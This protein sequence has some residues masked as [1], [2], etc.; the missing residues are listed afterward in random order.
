MAAHKN[1]KSIAFVSHLVLLLLQDPPMS[2]A[3][4]AER[5]FILFGKG[6]LKRGW[7]VCYIT[8]EISGNV[9]IKTVM[10]VEAASFSFMHGGKWRI[11]LNCMS[12]LYAMWRTNSYYYVIKTP[13]YF[14]VPM[15]LFTKLF[16]RRLVFWAQSDSDAYPELRPSNKFVGL[17]QDIGTR[18][19]DIIIAQNKSQLIGFKNNFGKEAILI[20]NITGQLSE[21]EERGGQSG[22]RVDIL[23]VGNSMPN[24]RYEVVVALAEMLPEFTFALAMN[25]SHPE[26]YLQAAEKCSL[27]NNIIFLGEVNPIEMESWF[28][29]SRLLLN[30]SAREGFP[31]TYLQAWQQGLPIVSICIDPDGLVGSRNLGIVFDKDLAGRLTDDVEHYANILCP[32]I[33][34]L[35]A[36]NFLYEKIS[37]NAKKYVMESHGESVL[38]EKLEKV[39]CE[40]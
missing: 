18:C 16:R 3:G 30:T 12:I 35:L 38:V 36:D 17:F 19:A 9:A 14:L 27:I 32:I 6:L 24:K 2:G 13:S 5:Q 4:G 8:D 10:P 34:K 20:P 23:W 31:N 26:R 29:R 1:N 22:E 11:P 7:S 33:T 28:G 21:G 15:Y 40:V 25:K 39:L 37:E